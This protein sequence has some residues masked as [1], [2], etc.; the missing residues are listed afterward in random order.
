MKRKKLLLVPILLLL[1]LIGVFSLLTSGFSPENLPPEVLAM[2]SQEQL[3]YMMLVNPAFLV[4]MSVL[5][6]SLVLE[7]TG[8]TVPFIESLI[9]GSAKGSI[10]SN[11]LKWGVPLGLITGIILYFFARWFEHMLP[12]EFAMLASDFEPSIPMKILYGGITEEIMLRFG[13]MSVFV[14]LFSKLFKKLNP[15][16]YWVSIILAAILFGMGH[17]GILFKAIET[18][19]AAI[20]FYVLTGNSIAGL[21]LGWIY[22]KK[23]LEASIFGHI[24]MHL[25]MILL[26]SVIG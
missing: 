12:G 14:W 11:Q 20:I 3:R 9:L 7:R 6:G 21:V 10:L 22:W 26:L 19:S 8:L 2:F 1:G 24:C 18:P 25:S 4:I 16:V 15:A 5:A 23:G 17:L 13:L